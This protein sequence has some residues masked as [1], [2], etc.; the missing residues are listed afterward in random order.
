[1]HFTAT[2]RAG[3]AGTAALTA[4]A[5]C[6][7]PAQAATNPQD[8]AAA[9]LAAAL[10]ADGNH[11]SAS[12]GGESY[13]DNG[14][15][16]DAVLGLAA[17]AVGGNQIKASTD[18]L[19]ANAAT[20]TGTSAEGY[21]GGTAKQAVLL[22]ATG[23]SASAVLT[24]LKGF[25]QPD[26]RFSDASEWGDYSSTITQSWALIALKR[27]G[28]GATTKAIDFLA[29]Q[30]CSDGGFRLKL[31]DKTCVSDPDATSFAVQALAANGRTGAVAK[32]GDY[33]AGVQTASGGVRGGASTASPNSNST[34]LAAVA[35]TLAGKSANA[36]RATAFVKSLQFGCSAPVGLRGAIAYDK[37]SFDAQIAKGAKATA[38]DQE[39]RATPQAMLAL[40]LTPYLKVS[41]AGAAARVPAI[42][43]A[44]PTSARTP[45]ASPTS[46]PT[47]SA[48]T[49][50]APVTSV[51]ATSSP[52]TGPAVV[53]DGPVAADSGA[54]LSVLAGAGALI[55]TIGAGAVALGRRRH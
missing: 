41:S 14:L 30:Q 22:Q 44:A 48:S 42:D 21:V 13:P 16:V 9:Y 52:V 26:G 24:Q 20:Y 43:C 5:L 19:V 37:P 18:W 34:G 32:A 31:A 40:T 25:E 55:A 38:S 47:P 35:F 46:A 27:A 8:A 6:S 49:S 1:M 17:A 4:I 28:A 54:D 7:A 51:P 45:S 53:T 10:A 2:A 33:L 15:T 39:N 23:R 50:S 12:Y 3:L 36:A 29:A 11:L